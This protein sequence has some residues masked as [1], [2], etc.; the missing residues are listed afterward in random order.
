[1]NERGWGR[2]WGYG[3]EREKWGVGVEKA[4]ECSVSVKT[5]EGQVVM[6]IELYLQTS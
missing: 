1:M 4:R 3:E 2:E 5:R 6:T